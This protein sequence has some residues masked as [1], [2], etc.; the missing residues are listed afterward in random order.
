MPT[1]ITSLILDG[2]PYVV[3]LP[4]FPL[5]PGRVCYLRQGA[6]GAL[7]RRHEPGTMKLRITG[8]VQDASL[9]ADPATGTIL[10]ESVLSPWR[11]RVVVPRETG[12]SYREF[13]VQAQD[14]VDAHAAGRLQALA[15]EPHLFDGAVGSVKITALPKWTTQ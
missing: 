12:R 10:A 9:C 14:R 8:C 6:A 11:V 1:K 7:L 2:K 15:A 5:T 4:A 3:S 13:D